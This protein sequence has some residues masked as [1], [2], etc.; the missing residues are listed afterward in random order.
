MISGNEK[1]MVRQDRNLLECPIWFVNEREGKNREAGQAYSFSQNGYSFRT[2]GKPPTGTD[3]IFLYFWM[4]CIQENN[5][6]S[7]L[8]IS[9]YA[10]LKGCKMNAG[11][12]NLRR[13]EDSIDRWSNVRIKYDGNFYQDK[14]YIYKKFGIIN[15]ANALR[16]RNNNICGFQLSFNEEWL[17]IFEESKFYEWLDFDLITRLRQP[18]AI[19][20][21]E[22][23]TKSFIGRNSFSI[24][25]HKMASKIPIQRQYASQILL[26]VEGAMDKINK[27]KP[28]L[29][30]MKSVKKGRNSIILQFYVPSRKIRTTIHDEHAEKNACELTPKTN[31]PEEI[32]AELPEEYRDNASIVQLCEKYLK[33]HANEDD[34]VQKLINEIEYTKQNST[35]NGKFGGFLRTSCDNNWGNEQYKSKEKAI[36]AEKKDRI[37]RNAVCENPQLIETSWLKSTV[38]NQIVKV[39]P[40]I[41]TEWPYRQKLYEEFITKYPLEKFGTDQEAYLSLAEDYF[42]KNRQKAKSEYPHLFSE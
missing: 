30:S 27:V 14:K 39:L 8:E 11:G 32:M 23:L 20:L 26:L 29:F 42:L 6:T 17:S 13:V 9:K 38:R 18:I 41:A 21:Y 24:D 5:W 15:N 19:R 25:A 3:I 33:D 7:N 40:E 31:I 2:H 4:L 10:T 37:C 1:K 16:G 34:R 12:A 22:Y 28:K 35:Q 36:E